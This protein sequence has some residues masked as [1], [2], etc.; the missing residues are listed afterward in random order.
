MIKVS[1]LY[2]NKED[3]KF[4][5]DYYLNNHMTM[6]QEKLGLSLKGGNVDY[7]LSGAEPG[8]RAEFV[9]MSH[10]LFDSVEAFQKAFG[11]NADSILAD[12]PNYTDIQPIFQISEV[13]V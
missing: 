6:V 5:L 11:P 10:L 12:V 9:V 13:K 2:P 4:N 7:G 1:V 8:S 3:C